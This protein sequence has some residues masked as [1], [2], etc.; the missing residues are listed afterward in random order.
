MLKVFIGF[1]VKFFRIRRGDLKFHLHIFTDININ[2]AKKYWIN[3]LRISKGQ[4]YK[5]LISRSGSIGTYRNK[6]KYG[7]MTLYYGNTKLRNQL[8]RLIEDNKP[9]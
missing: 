3:Q 2:K 6:S 4:I 8:V 5:P 7:V 9:T 1:L